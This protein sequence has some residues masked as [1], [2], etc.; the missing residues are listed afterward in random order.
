MVDPAILPLAHWDSFYVIVG[1]SGAAL[2][3][4]QF[5][6]IA[7]VADL[8]TKSSHEQI[9]AYATPT[10][11]HFGAALLIST[12]MSAPWPTLASVAITLRLCAIAGVAYVAIAL[13]RAIRQRDYKPVFDDWL[14][15]T[16]IPFTVYGVLLVAAILLPSR[17]NAAL[18]FVGGAALSLLF[19]GI[20]N[21]WD[22]VTYIVVDR[23]SET[24]QGSAA[25]KES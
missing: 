14:W 17:E 20:H 3:G 4:L 2:I 1:S 18:F 5:V 13:W 6:V 9:S 8:R 22:T 25:I 7:L 10:I 16:I 12:I 23:A 21:S 24:R 19:I 15:H 11:V